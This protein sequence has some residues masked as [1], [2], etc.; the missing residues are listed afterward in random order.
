MNQE[1][2]IDMNY[3]KKIA[4]FLMIC[5]IVG[6]V[7]TSCEQDPLKQ[8]PVSSFTE[9]S[10]FK[11]IDLTK[12]FLGQCYF[13]MG[14]A[15]DWSG[16]PIMG[17]AEDL[18]SSATDELLCIHRPGFYVWSK[19]NL[20]PS[21][22]GQWA[23][24]WWWET[25]PARFGW[26]DWDHLYS[27]IK[28]VNVLLANIDGVPTETSQ[29]EALKARMK[30]EAHF[31][32][33]FSYTNLLRTYGGVPLLDKPF[34]L[35][36]DFS[37]IKRSSIAET[38]DF[39]LADIEKAIN[40]L[41]QKGGIE[42]GRATQGAAAALKVRLLT[43][44][45]SDLVNG[46]YEAD[47]P[48]VSFQEG[49]QQQRWQ[50]ARDAAKALIDGDYGDYGLAGTTSDP[51]ANMNME[52]IMQY[53]DNFHSIFLQKGAWNDEIIWGINYNKEQG[54]S[55]NPNLAHGPNGYHNWGNNNP[56]EKFVREF[57]MADGSEFD[58]DGPASVTGERLREATAAELQ[59]NPYLDP[60]YKREPRFY[61]SV[62]YH[63]APWQERPDD[64][65]APDTIQTGYFV[66][67]GGDHTNEDDVTPGVDTRQSATESWNGTKTGYYLKKFMDPEIQGQYENNEHAWAEIRYAEILLDYAEACIELDELSNGIDALN[68]VRNRAGL[69]DRPVTNQT[70]AREFVRHERKI[71][72]FGEGTRWFDLR[73]WMTA[74]EALTDVHKMNVYEWEDGT[75]RWEW[76]LDGVQ[77]SRT[78]V[79]RSL[80]LP[81]SYEEMQRA[82][83]LTQNPNY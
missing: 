34:E 44:C 68:Q 18:L 52:Q 73:R 1:K 75:M 62:L 47:N 23:P 48:L 72:F 78:W 33:A 14:E 80:W 64:V 83:Q 22:L 5:V 20:S 30:A 40:G 55:A 76:N 66:V 50:A 49:T 77:D 19:G 70:E 61:A 67:A 53:A 25:G 3:I 13:T 41:P 32:R 45:A 54:A 17:M 39:I 24:I 8:E 69:P 2:S 10:V 29:E 27:N 57:E 11:D 60:Y 4:G 26:L 35:D 43:F 56:Q 7:P 21:E 38:R 59:S 36:Q 6:I 42:Q 16:S 65:E 31:I 12:S 37:E 9:K 79:Q 15:R 51:P 58:W 28:N 71:E 46:G 63:G 82:P 74:D 81:I